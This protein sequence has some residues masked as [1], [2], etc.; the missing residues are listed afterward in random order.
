M[1]LTKL[2]VLNCFTDGKGEGDI[3][4]EK[5]SPVLFKMKFSLEHLVICVYFNNDYENLIFMIIISSTI[6]N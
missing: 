1:R 5:V 3:S 6:Y 2:S 4:V